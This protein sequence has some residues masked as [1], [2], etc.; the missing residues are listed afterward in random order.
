LHRTLDL[1]A[2]TKKPRQHGLTAIHEVGCPVGE[3]RHILSD[4]HELL[5]IAKLGVGAAYITPKLEEKVALYREFQVECYFGGT[6]FEKFYY[7]SKIDDYVSYLKDLGVNWVEISTGTVDISLS[8]RARLIE[9]FNKDFHVVSEVGSK[10]EQTVMPPSEWM[11]EIQTLLDAGARYV[12]TEGRNSGTAGVYRA[13]GEIR[14]GL[15]ADIISHLDVNR[16]IFEAPKPEHQMYFIK[17][18]GTNV[19]LGNVPPRDLLLLEA[20]RCGLRY[21]T[22]FVG[23]ESR[24]AHADKADSGV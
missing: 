24:K 20:Q 6:L 14:T 10:D 4:F 13:S 3:L 15:V 9:R 11:R 19:N 1:P 12:I 23:D 8:D 17:Q 16:I 18:V 22:F 7:Q 5:D 21:E 2:R